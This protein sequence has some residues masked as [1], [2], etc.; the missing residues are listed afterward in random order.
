MRIGREQE[1][2]F[3]PTYTMSSMANGIM[4]PV[5]YPLIIFVA[6]ETY[7]KKIM[8]PAKNAGSDL[9]SAALVCH[10]ERRKPFMLY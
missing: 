7:N 4:L 9:R 3:Q 6:K 2:W 1:I 10:E 5:L 8:S